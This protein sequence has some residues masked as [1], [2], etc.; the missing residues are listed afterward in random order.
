MKRLAVLCLII[1]LIGVCSPS[2]GYILVYKLTSTIK[3]VET[4]ANAM[5]NVKVSGYLALDIND[6]EEI[7][8]DSRMVIYGK[9][10]DANKVYYVEDFSGNP[11]VEWT[12]EGAYL[13]V[14]MINHRGI[15]Y[16]DLRL[17]G[18]IKEKDVGFGADDL[19]NAASSAKG[20]MYSTHGS[21][22]DQGQT[23]FGSG[24]ATMTLDTKKTKAANDVTPSTLDEIMTE[25][26]AGEGGLVEKGYQELIIL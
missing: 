21:L 18:K 5:M 25:I 15:F 6:V 17:T 16:Y 23:L 7:V 12:E 20:S 8:D 13:T 11:R 2:Y 19:R 14:E 10:A 1:G 4:D 9:D 3:T 22:F 24:S 26:V